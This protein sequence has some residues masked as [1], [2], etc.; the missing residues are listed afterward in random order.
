VHA[1]PPRHTQAP[2][3]SEAG[4][5]ARRSLYGAALLLASGVLLI[6]CVG[7][8]AGA[9]GRWLPSLRVCAVCRK[10]QLAWL[11][12]P[13]VSAVG[14]DCPVPHHLKTAPAGMQTIAGLLGCG[15]L[16]CVAKLGALVAAAER[17]ERDPLVA[18]AERK[19]APVDVL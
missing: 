17:R 1:S 8:Y 6:A 5:A 18:A 10:Q 14:R 15:A 3:R 16:L 13:R 9:L 2:P 19:H 7:V 12:T 4:A 11:K